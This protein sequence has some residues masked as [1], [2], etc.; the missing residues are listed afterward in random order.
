M[1]TTST[2]RVRG[3]TAR[4]IASTSRLKG[5]GLNTDNQ[6]A[7]LSFQAVGDAGRPGRSHPERH[8]VAVIGDGAFPSGIVFE[9]LN[10]AGG[11]RKRGL[12]RALADACSSYIQTLVERY[13]ESSAR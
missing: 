12:N 11:L 10:N 7:A 9:A 2:A 8:S 1:G 5:R 6:G 3:V 13:G 4:S